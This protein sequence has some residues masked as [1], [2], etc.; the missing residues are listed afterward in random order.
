MKYNCPK[1]EDKEYT[2]T[3]D[4]AVKW[5]ECRE[6]R[7]AKE[8]IEKSG[9]SYRFDKNKFNNYKVNNFQ[10]KNAVET[11]LKY[12]K[13]FDKMKCLL[14]AGQVGS[15]KTH[16]AIATCSVLLKSVGVRYADFVNEIARMKFNQ[17]DQED[18]TKTLDKY[19][20][21]TVL[22][23]D[24]LY[25]GD[26]SPATQR[27]VQDIV[28]YRYNNNKAMIITT[29]LDK[30]G[31]LKINEATASRII[32]MCSYEE[33]GEWSEY[34]VEFKGRELNHRLFKK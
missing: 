21:V 18:F 20:N 11:C 34:I 12:I 28:N 5:C 25:K 4:N 16:L 32:E 15:G 23:I 29:E 13:S 31:L 2:I 19:R 10:R 9:L 30:D 6:Q 17:L 14:L 24:D 33:N 3:K 27:I 7:L 1:C 22:F 8:R 26:V